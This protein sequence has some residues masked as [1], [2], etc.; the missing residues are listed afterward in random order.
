MEVAG[1]AGFSGL[2]K[3]QLKKKL[4]LLKR[5]YSKTLT[6][7]Q[8]AQRAETVQTHVQETVAEQNRLLRQEETEKDFTGSLNKMPPNKYETCWLQTNSCSDLCT[9]KKLSVSFKLEPECFN[10]EISLQESPWEEDTNG[11]QQDVLSCPGRPSSERD[12]NQLHRTEMKQET[13]F[14]S[15]EKKSVCDGLEIVASELLENRTA[16]TVS[17]VF[18]RRNISDTEKSPLNSPKSTAVRHKGN[19]LTPQ[20]PLLKGDL[21]KM[22]PQNGCLEASRQLLCA[23]MD[24]DNTQ[25]MMSLHAE[26][27][28]KPTTQCSEN[29]ML[30]SCENTDDAG[31]EPVYIENQIENDS[32]DVDQGEV[33]RILHLTSENKPLLDSRKSPVIESRSRKESSQ[34]DTK[35]FLTMDSLQS[36][37]VQKSLENQE[38]HPEAESSLLEK[39]VI[40]EAESALSSCTV[41]EG[42]LFPVEYY[43]RTTRRMSNCQRKVDLEAVILSQLGR[44]RGR[45]R[46][47]VRSK[48]K[49]I[50]T[51]SDQPFPPQETAGS[52]VQLGGALVPAVGR[53]V[54]TVSSESS[55]Q[56]SLLLSDE[57]GTSTGPTSQDSVIAPKRGKGRLQRRGRGRDGPA[58]KPAGNVSLELPESLRPMTG[59]EVHSRLSKDSQ[60]EKE[61]C[62][63]DAEKLQTGKAR[64]PVSAVGGTEETEMVHI[65]WPTAADLPPGGSRAF[66][67]CHKVCTEH[68][69][70]PCQGSHFLNHGDETFTHLIGGLEA[71]VNMHQAAGQVAEQAR[72]RRVQKDCSAQKLPADKESL[73]V[74][75]PPGSSLKRKAGRASKGKRRNSQQ[76]DLEGPAPLGHLV[77]PG[78]LEPP[79]HFQNKMLSP[80]WLPSVLEIRDFHLP[81]EEFG[82]LKDAKLQ[83]S[84]R[85]LEP[86]VP[87][88]SGGDEASG[89]TQLQR[90]NA[91]GQSLEHTLISPPKTVPPKLPHFEGQLPQQG[92]SLSEVLLIPLSAVSAG[93][94]SQLESQVPM[95]ALPSLGATPALLSLGHSG[96]L[97]DSFSAPSVQMKT[98]AAEEPGGHAVEGT[99]C[100]DSRI[101]RSGGCGTGSAGRDEAQSGKAESFL[102]NKGDPECGPDEDVLLEEHQQSGSVHKECCSSAAEQNKMMLDHMA[103]A[104]SGSLREGS[105]RLVSKLKDPSGSCAVDVSTVWWEETGCLELC[106]VTACETSVSLWKPL[107]SDQWRNTCT[108]HLTE[109]PVIQIVPLP[110]VHNLV[111]AA[112][113]DLEIGEL[114]VLLCSSED[115]SLKQSVVKTGNIK[116]VLGLKDR[117]LV[118]S[119]RTFQEQQVEIISFLETGRNN[120]RKTLMAPKETV[121]AF[122]EVEGIRDALIGTT[123]VNSVVVWNLKTGQL[124][125]KMHVG[126]S[127]PASVCH[128]AYSDSG[129]LFVVLSHPHAKE[130]ESCGNPAFRVIAFNPK[131][132]RS[133]GVMFLSLPPGHTGRYLEGE[134]KDTSAAAVLTSGTIAV[135]DLL[136][137]DCATLLPPESGRPWTLVRWSAKDSYLLAGQKDGSVCVYSYSP[138]TAGRRKEGRTGAS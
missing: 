66:D 100:S 35:S 111:C 92:L 67:T 6:R 20:D 119:S 26:D 110:D 32:A 14:V 45:S 48:C 93:A 121:L 12:Q 18:K 136:L 85:D 63:G 11:S 54:G 62:E 27:L 125:K 123:T 1:P 82:L 34:V 113:G 90:M 3:E 39:A 116:A 84:A 51:N 46:K 105:L 108:W 115:G 58:C 101:L 28:C 109:I 77:E 130:S 96:A 126:Y 65:M 57:S 98:D 83:S 16:R 80:K 137:G 86:F 104:W 131:T 70:S 53:E 49:Q 129:L 122:A 24:D 61:N 37:D 47:G 40:P 72:T 23:S 33:C 106:I 134:V 56:K 74:H 118:S 78:V 52:D 17:P 29:E 132:A 19:S 79:F 133:A 114:R 7:L 128:R 103:M 97:P 75:Q 31:K 50:K 135:W 102:E 4:A 95:P 5:E 15:E 71:K 117:R 30:V 138:A 68:V 99:E 36:N 13:T 60:S 22:S 2:E 94:P 73:P 42:L 87:V 69:Q 21:Q 127:Y 8:R 107:S 76:R 44:G 9:K 91:E 124:L 81:D 64:V 41:V 38:A 120:N 59:K 25:Q 88:P 112:L 10:N 89:G 43:V 55:S